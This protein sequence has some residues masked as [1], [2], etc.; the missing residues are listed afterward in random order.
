MLQQL[1]IYF[2]D[3]PVKRAYLFGSVVRD[4]QMPGSDVDILVELDYEHG[5]DFYAFLDMQEQLSELLGKKVDL[6]SANG[7]SPLIKP[8]IDREKQL[9]YEKADFFG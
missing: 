9:A 2:A 8:H 3:K 4:E 1:A 7:L 6:V 5:A